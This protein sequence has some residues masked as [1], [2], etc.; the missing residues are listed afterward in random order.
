MV[1]WRVSKT[2]VYDLLAQCRLPYTKIGRC[3]RVKLADVEAYERAG[4]VEAVPL[5]RVLRLLPRQPR[6]VGRKR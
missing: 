2:F 1:R 5:P 4:T 6:R 3:L